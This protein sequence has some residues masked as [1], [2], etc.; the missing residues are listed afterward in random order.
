[1]IKLQIRAVTITL[2]ILFTNLGLAQEKP[3]YS[4][5]YLG[6][7]GA[8]DFFGNTLH[9]EKVNSNTFNAIVRSSKTLGNSGGGGGSGRFI[10]GYRLN[11]LVSVSIS[12]GVGIIASGFDTDYRSSQTYN[13]LGTHSANDLIV[14]N[15][16]FASYEVS[17]LHRLTELNMRRK[18]RFLNARFGLGVLRN[19]NNGGIL[20]KEHKWPFV[21]IVFG[22]SA[23][24]TPVSYDDTKL[25]EVG[26]LPFA[27][28]GLEY[29]S[30]GSLGLTFA[31]DTHLFKPNLFEERS[32]LVKEAQES[33]TVT[34]IALK[35]TILSYSVSV[36]FFINRKSKK[37]AK[38]K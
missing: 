19:T 30:R 3:T 21:G 26:S 6:V 23:N 4:K 9:S 22:N 18:R 5:L 10:I 7:E 29:E 11:E 37:Q 12:L 35:N 14:L 32:I 2:L 36:G 28:L 8:W 24:D 13:N 17:L 15:Y 38:S 34:R 16:S 1:M 33:S 27:K 25:L 20:Y 31:F